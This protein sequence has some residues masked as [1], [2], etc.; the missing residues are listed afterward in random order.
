LLLTY[1]T[2]TDLNII[3]C[4]Q[5]TLPV[6]ELTIS[7]KAGKFIDSNFSRFF[8]RNRLS[9]QILFEIVFGPRSASF[10][11]PVIVLEG[12]KEGEMRRKRQRGIESVDYPLPSLSCS[13]NRTK[14]RE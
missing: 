1:P 2:Q 10:G 13:L 14:L 11:L 4:D 9:N 7:I 3:D 5:F 6:S 8:I 12:R